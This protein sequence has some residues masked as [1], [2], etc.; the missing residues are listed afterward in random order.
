MA[1]LIPGMSKDVTCA[2]MW[3]H[4]IGLAAPRQQSSRLA[5]MEVGAMDM[6]GEDVMCGVCGE[7]HEADAQGSAGVVCYRCGGYGRFA[8]DCGSTKGN[9]ENG[10]G[11]GDPKGAR[12]VQQ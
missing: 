1:V 11:K 5:P 2:G 7:G 4:A 8:R 6:G 9:G 3:W 12:G 10:S